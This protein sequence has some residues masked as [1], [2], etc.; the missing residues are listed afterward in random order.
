MLETAK[1]NPS[2]AA[3]TPNLLTAALQYSHTSIVKFLLEGGYS[4]YRDECLRTA[5]GPMRELF[6][7]HEQTAI[8]W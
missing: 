7:A 8:T 3:Y 5:T 6:L 4:W 1:K 2:C